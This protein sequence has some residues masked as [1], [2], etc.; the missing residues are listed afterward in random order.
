MTNNYFRLRG[1][2][3]KDVAVIENEDRKYVAF[4]IAVDRNNGKTNFLDVLCFRKD[5]IA[6]MENVKKGHFV[7]A[8]GEITRYVDKD[9]EYQTKLVALFAKPYEWSRTNKDSEEVQ[10]LST[11]EEVQDLPIKRMED[12]GLELDMEEYTQ[13]KSVHRGLMIDEDGDVVRFTDDN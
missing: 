9:G 11:K 8:E 7:E 13:E 2:L 4:T 5:C 6:W 3:T 12:I 1:N 10:E